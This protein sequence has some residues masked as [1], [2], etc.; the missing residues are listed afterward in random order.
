MVRGLDYYTGLIFEIEIQ[1]KDGKVYT[2]GG[3]GHYS[4][5]MKELGGP[6]LECV[7]F[8]LGINRLAL[9]LEEKFGLEAYALKKEIYVLTLDDSLKSIAMQWSHQLRQAGFYVTM[10]TQHKSVSSM[11]KYAAKHQ[12]HYAV[13]FGEDELKNQQVAIKD[14]K[15]QKQE[16]ISLDEMIL[17]FKEVLK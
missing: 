4:D 15:L 7:G 3:G 11:F 12:F 14:L 9:L 5:L 6:D 16:V 13:I 1:G 8:G 10:E 17:Y 2:I